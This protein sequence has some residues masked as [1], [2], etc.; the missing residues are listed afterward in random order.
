MALHLRSDVKSLARV[1]NQNV[2]LN[3]VQLLVLTGLLL[4]VVLSVGGYAYHLKQELSSNYQQIDDGTLLIDEL[5][6]TN[7]Q[8]GQALKQQDQLIDK[9]RT[10]IKTLKTQNAELSGSLATT[11]AE[12][13][14]QQAEEDQKT[15]QCQPGQWWCKK[16]SD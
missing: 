9:Q 14:A 5:A 15:K 13:D 16:Y 3:A 8:M 1:L 11:Q 6:E 12:L 10:D 2:H 4:A 7:R